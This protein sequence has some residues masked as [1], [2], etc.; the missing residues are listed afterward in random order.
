[1]TAKTVEFKAE[2][3]QVLDLVIHSLYTHKE[4]FLRELISN[5]SDSI[6]KAKFLSLTN[7]EISKSRGEWKIKITADKDKNILTVTDNGIGMTEEEII[8]SLGTIAHSGTKEFIELIKSKKLEE[9]PELIGQFGVGFYS[10]FMVAD[11]VTVLSKSMSNGKA[12]KWESKADGTYTIEDV[13]KSAAGTEV[14]LK[15]KEDAKEY[16]DVYTLKNIVKKYSDYIEYPVVIDVEKEKEDKDNKDKKITTIEEETI[17]SM[18]AI[19]LKNKE[20]ITE[21]EY[22]EFYKHISHDFADPLKRIHYRAEGTQEFSALLYIPARA[23]FDMLYKDFKAGPSLYVK[24]VQIMEHCED[25]LPPY[26]R[27]VKGVVDSSD[28]PLNVSRETLQNNRQIT[29]IKNNLGKKVLEALKT[30]KDKEKEKYMEFFK[31][32]GRVIKEGIHYDY[33]KKNE[34]AE[35]IIVQSTKTGADKYID[36]DEYLKNMKKDQKEIYYICGKSI[37]EL[38]KSP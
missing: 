5:A 32:F 14:I 10:S 33:E 11:D 28:L 29:L 4:V 19:W 25:L 16:L 31:E 36:L 15:L 7:K 12:V 21:E 35:L 26:L 22:N 13:E 37:Q 18:K 24:K 17:N 34:L 3:K 6:D 38:K 27:F 8:K 2:V 20:D 23:P 9:N 1:M 30:L